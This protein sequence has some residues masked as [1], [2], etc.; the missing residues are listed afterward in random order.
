MDCS[1]KHAKKPITMIISESRKVILPIFLCQFVSLSSAAVGQ[2]KVLCHSWF[3]DNGKKPLCPAWPRCPT[4]P[5]ILPMDVAQ[6]KSKDNK[7]IILLRIT[8]WEMIPN[9]EFSI[10][11]YLTIVLFL[12]HLVLNT[13]RKL[14]LIHL[15]VWG[16]MKHVK[17]IDISQLVNQI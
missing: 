11:W 6:K 4:F 14:F 12:L 17:H 10:C 13:M 7:K 2:V 8:L 5:Y 1:I 3:C 9:I 15:S 16:V